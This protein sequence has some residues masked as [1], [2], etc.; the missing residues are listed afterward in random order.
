MSRQEG[1]V[2]QGQ[3]VKCNINR[4]L[5]SCFF[6]LKVTIVEELPCIV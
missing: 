2:H 3:D 1:K 6:L 4:S 5:V